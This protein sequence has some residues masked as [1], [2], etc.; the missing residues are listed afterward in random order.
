MFVLFDFRRF[1]RARVVFS[2][3]K[4]SFANQVPHD[5]EGDTVRAAAK[6]EPADRSG[7]DIA[8]LLLFIGQNKTVAWIKSVTIDNDA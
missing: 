3:K 5:T 6:V 8:T 1:S 7:E 4:S 2:K